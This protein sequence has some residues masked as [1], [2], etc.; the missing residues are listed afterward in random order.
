M[1]K[2]LPIV[3]ALCLSTFAGFAGGLCGQLAPGPQSKL[4][5]EPTVKIAYQVRK[6]LLRLMPGKRWPFLADP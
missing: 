5:H 1:S 2:K 4:Y 3:A 6:S